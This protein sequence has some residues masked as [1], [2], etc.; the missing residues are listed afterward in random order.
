MR[1]SLTWLAFL[2]LCGGTVVAA[3]QSI[4]T[5]L[6]TPPTFGR[7]ELEVWLTAPTADESPIVVRRAARQLDRDFYAGFDWQ[8]TLEALPPE[9]QTAFVERFQSLMGLLVRQ[10]ADAYRAEPSHRRERFLDNQLKE[11]ADW[12]VVGKQGKSSGITLF[13]QGL[14]AMS[15]P[16][17]QSRTPATVREFA[18]ALQAHLLKRS[19]GRVLPLGGE[20]PTR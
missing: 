10:R 5:D 17:I 1:R 3:V 11:L 12:Y 4:R 13:Q 16:Q 9:R 18:A 14:L 6:Q 19:L 20:E 2:V 15:S 7:A 8:P